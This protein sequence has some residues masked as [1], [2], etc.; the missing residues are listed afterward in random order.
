MN[1]LKDELEKSGWF[2]NE[3]GISQI[4]DTLECD[5]EALTVQQIIAEALNTD[6]RHISSG[7]LPRD[8]TTKS[9]VSSPL[10]LQILSITNLSTPQQNQSNF[11]RLLQ[12]EFTDGKK[13]VKG[14]EMLGE[15]EGITLNTPPG[16]KVSV[17]KNIVIR[18]NF[19]LLGPGMLKILGGEVDELTKEWKAGKQFINRSHKGAKKTG[20]TSTQEDG[21]PPFVPFKVKSTNRPPLTNVSPNNNDS[22][23]LGPRQQ[24]L[25]QQQSQQSGRGGS[26]GGRGDGGS[27][28]RGGNGGRDENE[29]CNISYAND[30]TLLQT[31]KVMNTQWDRLKI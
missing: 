11:P 31:T 7:S 28:G 3:E 15:V 20:N 19:L 12:I 27:R 26:R 1:S 14:F 6:L 22:N 13:K 8:I 24:S 30:R 23:N 21:P 25:Q 16:I 5:I 10:V 9:H 18:D 29:D 17:Q 4:A 2:L